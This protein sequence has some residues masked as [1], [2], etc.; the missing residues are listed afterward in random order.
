M[1]IV[2]VWGTR[3]EA[4]KVGPCVAELRSLGIQPHLIATGQHWDLLKGTPAETDLADSVSLGFPAN[5]DPRRWAVGALPVLRSA[6]RAAD[7]SLVCVQG[8]TASALAGASAAHDLHL[9]VVHIEAGVR[10][11]NLNE[12][13][14]EEG[15]RRQITQ[16]A[17]GVE[18]RISFRQRSRSRHTSSPP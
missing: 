18:S 2:F 3:P 17:T 16:L 8:D 10:S 13:W 4:L 5:G 7:A 14:P 6:L 15:F 11:E 12:P 1:S 9:P